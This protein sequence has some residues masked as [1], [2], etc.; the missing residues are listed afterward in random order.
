MKDTL[1][2]HTCPTINLSTILKKLPIILPMTT[3]RQARTSKKNLVKNL[4]KKYGYLFS[5]SNNIL[6]NPK[7]NPAYDT[8][9]PQALYRLEQAYTPFRNGR[10]EG[11]VFPDG[12][13]DEKIA[14]PQGQNGNFYKYLIQRHTD[15]A[16]TTDYEDKKRITR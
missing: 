9:E 6:R 13:F 10:F 4:K 7:G 1:S 14:N 2:E 16:A 11:P 3:H 8:G 15:T 5:S 12:M